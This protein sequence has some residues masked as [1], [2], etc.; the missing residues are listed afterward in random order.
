MPLWLVNKVLLPI[1]WEKGVQDSSVQVFK[2][3]F[4]VDRTFAN[5]VARILESFSSTNSL[6]ERFHL[7]ETQLLLR[8][9]FNRN[10]WFNSF[11]NTNRDFVS[12]N[13]F[14]GFAE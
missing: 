2:C 14:D 12:A 4:S 3:L 10:F 9:Y 8:Y 1:S 11:V 7:I 5:R 6:G 13:I